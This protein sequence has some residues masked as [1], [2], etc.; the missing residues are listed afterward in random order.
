MNTRGVNG[1]RAL[2]AEGFGP[3]HQIRFKSGNLAKGDTLLKNVR[4]LTPAAA[5]ALALPDVVEV[6]PVRQPKVVVFATGDE[7]ALPH[8]RTYI[9]PLCAGIRQ[10]RSR[11]AGEELRSD[12]C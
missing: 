11:G 10:L 4:R 12:I 5:V 3:E 8:F 1:H 6:E 7:L 2:F 9:A